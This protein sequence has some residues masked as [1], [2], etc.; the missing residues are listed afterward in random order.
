MIKT[1]TQLVVIL[2]CSLIVIGVYIYLLNMIL[3]K[4]MS[5][6]GKCGAIISATLLTYVEL[7]LITKEV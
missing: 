6:L 5:Q 2:S 7:K 4:D 1:K 3:N